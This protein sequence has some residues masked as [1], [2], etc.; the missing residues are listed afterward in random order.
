MKRGPT[1]ALPSSQPDV[2]DAP[3]TRGA[4]ASASRKTASRPA[5]KASKRDQWASWLA[6]L[7]QVDFLTELPHRTRFTDHLGE[8][9]ARARRTGKL[10][11]VVLLNVDHFRALNI[12]YGHAVGDA[13]LKEAANRLKQQTRKS[14]FVARVGGDEFAVLL[15]GVANNDGALVAAHRLMGAL[16]A[17]LQIDGQHIAMSSSAGVAFFPTDGD[18]VEMLLQNAD[19]AL[20]NAREY[21]RNTC[22]LYSSELRAKT[23]YREERRKKIVERLETL[24][25]RERE[26][27]KILVAG[28]ANKMIAYMLGTST[29]TIE[30]HRASIMKKMDARSLPDLVRMVMEV[31]GA[32]GEQLPHEAAEP[33]SEASGRSSVDR[34]GRS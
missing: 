3:R 18:S 13:V 31:R 33:R 23:R 25:P 21:H 20:C 4:R 32:A 27:S 2:P 19:I 5:L 6:H 10:V 15:E 29:R 9:I 22:Q 11:G 34:G 14:D 12:R 17:P 7:A 24:T 30:T 8:A 28:N 1:P 16:A 26:V